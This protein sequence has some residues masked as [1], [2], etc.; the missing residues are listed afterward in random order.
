MQLAHRSR[1]EQL[2]L[3][4]HETLIPSRIQVLTTDS[5]EPIEWQRRGFV[6]LEDGRDRT[7][8]S[9]E[10]KTVYL[11]ATARYVKLIFEKPHVNRD[12]LFGQ[13][14]L[15][16]LVIEGRKV[17]DPLREHV[18]AAK[19]TNVSTLP[20]Q[21]ANDLRKEGNDSAEAEALATGLDDTT[22]QIVTDLVSL[23]AA[24]VAREDYHAAKRM[25][26][27]EMLVR[28]AGSKISRLEI[29]L[30]LAVD[31]E[32]YDRAQQIKEEKEKVEERHH[33]HSGGYWSIRKTCG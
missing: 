17:H 3:L 21:E 1:I 10:L 8:K 26:D 16:G 5:P 22:T 19:P 6:R 25:K 23:K 4:A 14:S 30:R 2:Q 13:I 15:C 28:G 12:N 27:A 9:R 20:A 7:V 18:Q 31:S 24:A 33:G 32:S 29:E 11:E